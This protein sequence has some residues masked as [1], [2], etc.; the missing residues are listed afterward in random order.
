MVKLLMRYYDINSGSIKIDGNDVRDFNRSE[1]R[2]MFGMVLQDTW[3]TQATVAENIAYGKPDATREEIVAAAK[4]A[5][6]H[7]FIT[8]LKDGYDTV[9]TE[10]GANLSQGQKQLLCI[11]RVMLMNP[12]MLI[13]DEATSNID[14][15][16]ELNV[17]RAFA[18]MVKGRTSFVVAHR[19][20]TIRESNVILVMREGHVVEQGSHEELLEKGGFYKTLYDSQFARAE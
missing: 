13:L 2:E 17:Q 7:G 16:T 15:R 5:Y 3:L 12:A 19:L 6:A 10:Q 20:S 9:L 4:A 11:A 18:A 1:L 14:T 8:R